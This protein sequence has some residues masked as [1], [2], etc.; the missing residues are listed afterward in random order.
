MKYQSVSKIANAAAACFLLLL[1]VGT[2]QSQTPPQDAWSILQS[3]VTDKSSPK[4]VAAVTVLALI[5][6]DA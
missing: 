4:R 5:P 2:G 6:G 1:G 3:G